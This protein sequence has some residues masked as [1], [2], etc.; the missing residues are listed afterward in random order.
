MAQGACWIYI[1]QQERTSPGSNTNVR[2][3]ESDAREVQ[4]LIEYKI[5]SMSWVYLEVS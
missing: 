5:I 1:E 4:Y 3:F 2:S